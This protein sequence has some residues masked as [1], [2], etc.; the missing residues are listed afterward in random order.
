MSTA[1]VI[2]LDPPCF[3]AD[4]GDRVLAKGYDV[5]PVKHGSKDPAIQGWPKV[6]PTLELVHQWA[7]LFPSAGIGILTART[8]AVD[9][10]IRDAD[11]AAVMSDFVNWQI[12]LAPERIGNAPKLIL[13]FRTDTPFPKIV[14]RKY[15][16]HEGRQNQVEIL[17]VGQFFVAYGIHPDTGKPYRWEKRYSPYFTPA[18]DLPLITVEIAWQIIE[19]FHELAEARG[20]KEDIPESTWKAEEDEQRTPSEPPDWKGTK[21]RIQHALNAIPVEAREDYGIWFDCTSAL[22]YESGGNDEGREIG[23]EWS[24]LASNHDVKKS[25]DYHWDHIIRKTGRV[26]TKRTIYRYAM[27]LGEWDPKTA[28]K[29]QNKPVFD[30]ADITVA[31]WLER[32]IPPADNLLGEVFSTTSRVLLIGPTGLGKTNFGLALAFKMA[33]GEGFLH[34]EG[35]GRPRRVLYVDGEMAKGVM[36]KRLADV[37]RRSSMPESLW[38]LNSEDFPDMQPLNTEV[39][40]RWLD[41][42]IEAIGDVDF[43]ILDNMQ[44]L[45]V[46]NMKDDPEAWQP[47]LIWAKSLTARHIGQIWMHHTGRDESHGYGDQTREWQMDVVMLMERVHDVGEADIAFRLS[48]SKAR[49]RSPENRS[50]FDEVTITLQDD[51]WRAKQAV[52]ERK[53]PKSQRAAL[54]TLTELIA[55][56]G[57]V[58]EAMWRGTC[59]AGRDVCSSENPKSRRD[60]FNRTKGQ[61]IEAGLVFVYDD[62][63]RVQ[64]HR[65]DEL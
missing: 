37:V 39:G 15:L 57:T 1:K 64:L 22:Q 32:D 18:E 59:V 19:K 3:L 20:W 28:P 9:L 4:R 35:C 60:V 58:S 6:K 36:Q 54:A 14:S 41:E 62:G 61:L 53:L 7:N 65:D 38:L 45:L 11:M 13:L 23:R 27:E 52:F 16:D 26:K 31:A 2:P 10:D 34:W 5:I 21:D 51:V 47:V 46:G 50:D 56:H 12:G 42:F 63:A 55:Q 25:F 29:E 48:Y 49:P 33:L 44:A 43:I 8:P 24:P 30:P 17:G 40:Q